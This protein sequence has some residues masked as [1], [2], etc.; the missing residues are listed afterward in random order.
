[1]ADPDRADERDRMP[2]LTMSYALAHIPSPAHNRL[3]FAKPDLPVKNTKNLCPEMIYFRLKMHRS[4]LGDR[5]KPE[6]NLGHPV[7]GW[8]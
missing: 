2:S 3:R 5:A 7:S 1:M 8:I 6:P 4:V